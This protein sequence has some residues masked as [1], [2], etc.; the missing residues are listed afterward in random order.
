MINNFNFNPQISQIIPVL[1]V[2]AALVKYLRCP[3]EFDVVTPGGTGFAFH[4][5]GW[6]TLIT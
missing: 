5:G 4:R 1:S 6:I 2:G 3:S